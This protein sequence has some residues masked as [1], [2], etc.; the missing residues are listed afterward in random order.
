[1]L[2]QPS[3]PSAGGG[4]RKILIHDLKET[5][6]R[7]LVALLGRSFTRY[8]FSKSDGVSVWSWKPMFLF[9]TNS[10]VVGSFGFSFSMVAKCWLLFSASNAY[11]DSNM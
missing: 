5:S 9:I 10:N 8:A 6:K 2:V 3:S 7:V 1:M 11:Q 4:M